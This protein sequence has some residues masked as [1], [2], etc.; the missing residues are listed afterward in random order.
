MLSNVAIAV[1]AAAL[2][3]AVW[4]AVLKPSDERRDGA[5]TY[6]ERLQSTGALLEP[7]DACIGEVLRA[8]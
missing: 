7:M 6:C 4:F 2:T 5:R 3:C 1:A 8:R